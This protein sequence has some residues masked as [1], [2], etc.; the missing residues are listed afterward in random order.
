MDLADLRGRIDEVDDQLV[1]L[2][3]ERMRLVALVANAKWRQGL[4]L[5][6]TAREQEIS[7]RTARLAGREFA[8]YTRR[9]FH[10]LFSVSKDYQ[11]QRAAKDRWPNSDT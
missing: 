4:P 9:F 10:T 2:F 1:K 5:S 8:P 3:C 6:D 11:I 7:E